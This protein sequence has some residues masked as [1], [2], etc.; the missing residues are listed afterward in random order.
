MG[1]AKRVLARLFAVSCAGLVVAAG[2]FLYAKGRFEAPGPLDTDKAV[3]IEPGSGVG[4]IAEQLAQAGIVADPDLF[5]LGARVTERARSLK[6]GEFLFPAAVSMDRA[7]DILVEGKTVQHRVTV[8]EGTASVEVVALLAAEPLLNG[9]IQTIPDE[10]SLLPETYAYSR[11]EE[12]IAVI[13][14]MQAAM[15]E[16]VAALWADRDAD[17]P[18][19]TVEEAVILA[20]IVQ[21]ESGLDSEKPLIAGV[22]VNRL[23]RGMRLQSDPTVI[24]GMTKG[25]PLGRRLFRGD[26]RR[27]TPWNTY[28]IAELPPTP[29]TNPGRA[30]LAAVMKPAKTDY[31]YFVADGTGG[32]AFAR[33]L[34]EHNRNVAAWRR[35][36]DGET[37]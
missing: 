11:G 18:F 9:T 17:L 22:F 28:R 7:I 5:A 26:L 37:E 8:P 21:K 31:L 16:T 25:E 33:T 32:H 14:R 10:G 24:Y 15:T 34:A 2:V 29:I 30:A 1:A 23:R 12:R 35:I 4:V 20:S 27:E 19:E 3:V 13:A 36:R 6:A